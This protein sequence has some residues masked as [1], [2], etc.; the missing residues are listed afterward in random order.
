MLKPRQE[1]MLPK[2]QEGLMKALESTFFETA[3]L[4]NIAAYTLFILQDLTLS[5]T[6]KFN[7]NVISSIDRIFL[8]IFAAEIIL[9]TFASNG[10]YLFDKFNLF[11]AVIVFLSVG[12]NMQGVQA[13]G[14]GVL[15]LLRV[16]VITIRKITGNQSKLRH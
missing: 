7:P 9:K 15:R 4:I 10:S 8:W 2:L 5:D 6:L 11:D 3:S 14:L 13:K 1:P 16:V 12:F